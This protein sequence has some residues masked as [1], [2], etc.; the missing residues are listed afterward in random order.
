MA[1]TWWCSPARSSRCWAA[2][3]PAAPPR[4]RAVLGLTGAPQGQ[5][6]GQRHR[7]HRHADA[8]H[9]APGHRLLPG[10]ARHLR[11]PVVRREPA[12]AA[13][14]QGRGQGHV[15]RRDLRD[16]P[17]PGRA[18]PQ[19]GHAPVGRRAADAGGGAHPAHRRQAAAARRD[20]RR[21]GAGDRAGAG[22]HDPSRCAARATP[23]SWWSRTSAS[24]RRWPTAST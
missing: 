5:H 3:A 10:R 14:A 21:P 24:P 13:G 11:Q 9:R 6:Q 20:L 15:G 7:D 2:T 4:M 1:S 16:V 8:P 17:Q 18:P 12:A 19:P 22:P 23:S